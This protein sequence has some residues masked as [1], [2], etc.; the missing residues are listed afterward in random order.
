MSKSWLLLIPGVPLAL[1]AI[2]ASHQLLAQRVHNQ[3]LERLELT[4]AKLKHPAG[5]RQLAFESDLGLLQGNGNHCDFYA[6][7]LRSG[8]PPI[9]SAET[10][11]EVT[12]LH[13]AD[14][15]DLFHHP[16]RDR[17]LD[18]G[19]KQ[20]AS[21]GEVLYVVALYDQTPPESD[22]RCH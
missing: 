8:V 19:R 17:L 1:I 3:R 22:F 13:A 7:A 14:P 11:V 9:A 6:G 4:F 21:P 18:L 5:S 12:V 15:S 10:E 16:P 2:L 20:S